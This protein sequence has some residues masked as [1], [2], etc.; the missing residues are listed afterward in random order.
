MLELG[1][2]AHGRAGLPAPMAVT[3]DEATL[4]LSEVLVLSEGA[5]GVEPGPR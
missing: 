4:F 3:A 5:T 1:L 2:S